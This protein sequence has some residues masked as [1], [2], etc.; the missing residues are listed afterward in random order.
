MLPSWS[1]RWPVF[2]TYEAL[3]TTTERLRATKDELRRTKDERDV[4]RKL[5][6]HVLS[7]GQLK[8]LA[9]AHTESYRSA[10]P[11]PHIV[12]ENL[13]D[14]RL[15]REVLAEFDAMDREPW[16][17]T[18]RATERKYSSEDFQHFGPTTRALITQ[19]NA[20]PFLAFLEKLTG[21][22]GLIAD[23]HLRGGGLHE[24]RRGG[25]L[26]VHAD[27]NFYK[28]L[29]LYRRLNLLIYLNE[30]WSEEWG[31]DLELWDRSGQRCMQ[32][33]APLFNRVV[34]F[35]TSN[36]SYHGHPRPLQCP[37]ERSRKSLALYYY[38]VEAPADDD[39]TPHTTVFIQTEGVE[40]PE[41]V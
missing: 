23:P 33:I 37:E 10:D 6:A 5:F 17:Y 32:R 12:L 13:F 34:I 40:T 2:R 29:N 15:L 26:G 3:R 38:T 25:A 14:P 41:T 18:E 21:I 35:D 1:R 36:F 9:R 28:R 11:F 27:F 8:D 30:N 7:R 4:L 39:R 20:A 31:G 22:S 19:L 16:H 24:I